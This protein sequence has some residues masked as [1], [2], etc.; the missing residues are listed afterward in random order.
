M[1]KIVLLLLLVK[2]LNS[3]LY[4]QEIIPPS[5]IKWY[6]LNEALELAKKEPRPIMIDVYT[7][8]CSWCTFM[9]KT[10][11]SNTGISNYINSYYYAVR[12]NAETLDTVEYKG[13][14][15]FN[16][17]V[18]RQPV[19]DLASILLDGKFSYP[20]IVY[21]DR[22][23]NKTVVPGYKEPKDIEPIL[24]F[25]AE[26]VNKTASLDEFILNYMYSF[27]S[28]FEKDHSI[29]KI[30]A[31]LKPDTLGSIK[32]VTPEKI[33]ELQKKNPKPILMY[34]YTDWCISCK[35]MDKTTFGNRDLVSKINSKYYPVKIN[36]ASQDTISFLGKKYVGNGV[37]QPHQITQTILAGNFLMPAV[38]VFDEKNVQI[39][40]LNGYLVKS[41]LIPLT[42][43]F[44]DK[45]YKKLTFQDYLK[46]YTNGKKTNEEKLVN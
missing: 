25:Y 15:Y 26:N 40:N 18:G 12:F 31:S 19:H 41:Q 7:D 22:E 35:V 6:S 2:F 20:S 38:V 23:G 4:G 16:R 29:F 44:Y 17:R 43:Y 1:K 46:T 30:D 28:A 32:W 34:F 8:W 9:M 21:F 13:V 10:T 24:V 36:A 42:D 37:N 33:A 27:P 45:S 5:S 11:F 14:K 3:S 39:S